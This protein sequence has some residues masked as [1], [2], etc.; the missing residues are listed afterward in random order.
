MLH[1]STSPKWI[2]HLDLQVKYKKKIKQLKSLKMGLVFMKPLIWEGL[3]S[4]KVVKV[5]TNM[6][7]MYV[8]KLVILHIR[9]KE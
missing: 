4:F 1:L 3:L 9:K 6:S 2:F 7:L 8:Y 5:I